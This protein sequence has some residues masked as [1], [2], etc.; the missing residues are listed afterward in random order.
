MEN[1]SFKTIPSTKNRK[2]RINKL[3]NAHIFTITNQ[4]I[5]NNYSSMRHACRT[6]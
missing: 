6:I 3:S 4:S 2:I 1:E 5:G